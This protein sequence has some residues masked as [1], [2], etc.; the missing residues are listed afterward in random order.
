LLLGF[1][2]LKRVSPLAEPA[3]GCIQ[4]ETRKKLA[5]S[6]PHSFTQ[7]LQ[8]SRSNVYEMVKNRPSRQWPDK[9]FVELI[10]WLNYSIKYKAIDFAETVVEHLKASCGNEYTLEQVNRKLRFAWGKFH[11]KTG[12][13]STWKDLYDHGSEVLPGLDDELQNDIASAQGKLEDE[14][15]AKILS[16]HDRPRTR[17]A[18]KTNN[19]RLSPHISLETFQTKQKSQ[20]YRR[21]QTGS[22]TPSPAK[23]ESESVDLGAYDGLTP[24]KRVKRSSPLV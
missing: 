22:V 9:D 17:S 11:P 1:A 7:C 12:S 14:A 20:N 21:G 2:V 6:L 19:W 18:S 10:A 8:T 15:T 13:H 16:P 3:L 5:A 4:P 23:R 24:T